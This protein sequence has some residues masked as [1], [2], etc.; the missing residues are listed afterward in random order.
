MKT[1]SKLQLEIRQQQKLLMGDMR[2]LAN[3]GSMVKGCLSHSNHK[4]GKKNCRCS[5]G[6][7]HDTWLFSY[8]GED[9]K[10]INVSLGNKDLER[11][12]G[13]AED[14]R[15]FRKARARFVKR[16]KVLLKLYDQLEASLLMPQPIQKRQRSDHSAPRSTHKGGEHKK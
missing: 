1:T 16:H 13:P 6:H 5:Q 9:K 14:Y 2:I 11:Y 10:Q 4:C 8:M 3:A 12:R 7:L 15:E